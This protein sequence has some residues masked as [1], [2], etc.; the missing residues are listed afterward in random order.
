MLCY[1][2]VGADLERVLEE[3][4]R[5]RVDGKLTT[6]TRGDQVAQ[7]LAE[8]CV[9]LGGADS[10]C[11]VCAQ[12]V[13]QTNSQSEAQ[14][15]ADSEPGDERRDSSLPSVDPA[16][17]TDMHYH[18]TKRVIGFEPTRFALGK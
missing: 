10:A 1:P 6:M 7:A 9:R 14:A 17:S 5:V 12:R 3:T 18:S 16:L 15:C 4:V 8:T 11:A 2:R 13:E